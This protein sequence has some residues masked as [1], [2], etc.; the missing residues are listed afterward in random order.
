LDNWLKSYGEYSSES[1]SPEI[2]HLWVGL[3]VLAS[4]VRRNVWLN[5]GIYILY[6][7]LYTILVGPPGLGKSTPIRM[8]RKLLFETE[9]I[10]F[11]PDSVTR[12]ELIRIMAKAGK[13]KPQSA[14]TLHSSE[15]SSLVDPS[16]IKMI[17]FLTDIFDGD[18]KFQHGTRHSGRYTV[19][20]PILNILAATTPSWI[21]EGLPSTVVTHGFT[22]RTVFVYGDSPRYLKPFPNEPD[23][24]LTQDLINDLNYISLIE[25]EFRWAPGS[26]DYYRKIYEEA[27][28]STPK[29]FRL[30]AFHSRKVKVHVLKIAMLLSLAEGDSMELTKTNLEI[31]WEILREVEIDMGKTFS[32]MGKY[33]HA[34]DL[35]RLET[36]IVQEGGM[37]S[38]EIYQEFRAAGDVN[39][40]GKMLLMLIS[41]GHVVKDKNEKGET[42][43][44]PA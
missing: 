7:N 1:E 10:S 22:G 37:T 44:R 25:G 30:E 33:E 32:A 17:Q 4:A 43:Y 9:D 35:E 19:N 31:G 6:P 29:D 13:D 41:T 27:A 20:N 39:D 11:G 12:E 42:I 3:S 40:I 36:R 8:G 34:S 23:S 16:G 2:Y 38:Q 24:K 15:L 14:L 18:I 21:A 28:R 26:R 5:Q